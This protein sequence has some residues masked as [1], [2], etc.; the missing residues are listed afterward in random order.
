MMQSYFQIDFSSAFSVLMLASTAFSKR[1]ERIRHRSISSVGIS[2]GN[3][4]AA[5]KEISS[6]AASAA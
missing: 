6:F 2:A 5:L 4:I 3:S 1:L